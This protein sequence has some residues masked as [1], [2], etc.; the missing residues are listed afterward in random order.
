MLVKFWSLGRCSEHLLPCGVY[1]TFPNRG[2]CVKL[3]G[4]SDRYTFLPY[5]CQS[6][7]SVSKRLLKQSEAHFVLKYYMCR[8]F[9]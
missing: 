3:H 4:R 1:F 6:F 2:L 9:F 7:E 5:K 8:G